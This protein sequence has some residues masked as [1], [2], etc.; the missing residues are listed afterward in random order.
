MKR[1]KKVKRVSVHNY[2]RWEGKQWEMDFWKWGLNRTSCKETNW[3]VCN[4]KC[5]GKTEYRVRR[6]RRK[7]YSKGEKDRGGRQLHEQER[8]RMRLSV[9]E[10]RREGQT[11]CFPTLRRFPQ[12]T[13][14]IPVLIG[15]EFQRTCSPGMSVE[16][17]ERKARVLLTH[18]T[19]HSG[20]A[21]AQCVSALCWN[22]NMP[23]E[24]QHVWRI[25]GFTSFSVSFF[26]SLDPT[27]KV[28]LAATWH[29]LV[30]VHHVR[31][32]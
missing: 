12:Q 32:M 1:R 22:I 6:G 13:W 19:G 2:K 23:P 14:L 5:R 8:V 20:W 24:C 7:N 21:D 4:E 25:N 10:G 17:R 15:G 28:L 3:K 9:G 27:W 18:Q 30:V 31:S 16:R 11:L 26:S 29:C